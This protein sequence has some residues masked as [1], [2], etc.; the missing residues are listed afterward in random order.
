MKLFDV[1]QEAHGVVA[2]GQ[3]ATG[4]VAIGQVATGLIAIG[5]GARGVIAV[6]QGAIGLV[7]VGM[8]AVGLFWAAGLG[9]AGRGVGGILSLVPSLAAPVSI[10][11]TTSWGAIEAT[12]SGWLRVRVS[13]DEGDPVLLHDSGT[14]PARIDAGLV[15]AARGA[16]GQILLAR[17]RSGGVCDQLM[18]VPV[19]RLRQPRWWG[20]WA[21]QGVGLI[22]VAAAV[23]GIAIWP[24][25]QGSMEAL[26]L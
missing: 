7:A 11:K 13:E 25:I 14:L 26:G 24:A 5:Q 2:V 16:V 4:V 6:G 18:R 20:I 3:I 22:V 10:P 1:A 21:L 19:S 23:L 17:F 15:D 8:G 9:I 12:G